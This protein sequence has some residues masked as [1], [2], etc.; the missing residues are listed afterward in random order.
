MSGGIR[1]TGEWRSLDAGTVAALSGQLGV[2]E[3]ADADGVVVKIGT[4]GGLDPF[5]MRSAMT[6]ELDRWDAG[7]LFRFEHT[8]AYRTRHIELLMIHL[9]DHGSLP[10]CNDEDPQR[11]GRLSPG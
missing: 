2:Y 8:S 3:V 6:A 4:A 10:I 7:H 9:A 11:L 5:G 1:S